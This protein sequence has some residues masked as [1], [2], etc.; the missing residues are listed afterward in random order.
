MVRRVSGTSWRSGRSATIAICVALLSLGPCSSSGGGQAKASTSGATGSTT[1][2][3]VTTTT[4]PR[5]PGPAAEMTPLTGGHGVFMGEATTADL[6]RLG[7]AQQEYSAAGTARSY[8]AAGKL[9]RN[10]R[11]KFVRATTAPYRIR[12]L[13]RAPADPKKFSGTVVVA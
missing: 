5:P 6:G 11:W 1:A 13:V 12:V 8:N 2:P 9:G 4:R 10:G 7:Y 3:A